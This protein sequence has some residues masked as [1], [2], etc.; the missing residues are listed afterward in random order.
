MFIDLTQNPINPEIISPS[1]PIRENNTKLRYT[2]VLQNQV[3]KHI[4]K[5]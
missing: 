2:L 1:N 4:F 3:D 5:S